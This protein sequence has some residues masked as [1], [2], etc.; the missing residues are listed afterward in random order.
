MTLKIKGT[1]VLTIHLIA[2]CVGKNIYIYIYIWQKRKKQL[3]IPCD[4][5]HCYPPTCVDLL[6]GIEWCEADTYILGQICF[7]A[8]LPCLVFYAFVGEWINQG[9]HYEA[10]VL[11]S[12]QCQLNHT[13]NRVCSPRASLRAR[14][15]TNK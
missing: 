8:N 6:S 13:E 2:M 1:Y 11:F 14:L 10:F 3:L 15:C 9:F 12:H 7:H 4:C 5:M